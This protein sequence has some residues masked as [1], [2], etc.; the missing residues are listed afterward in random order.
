MAGQ[1]KL[2]DALAGIEMILPEIPQQHR[3]KVGKELE[4]LLTYMVDSGGH[5]DL[6][7]V[8]KVF[9]T[10][11]AAVKSGDHSIFLQRRGRRWQPV[12]IDQFIE[13]P[14][15]LGMRG[16]I[17]PKLFDELV[18]IFHGPDSEIIREIVLG[19]A[20]GCGKS[21]RAQIILA[22]QLYLLSCYHNP[23]VE[24]G[25]SSGS[26]IFFVFQSISLAL[27]KKVLFDQFSQLLRRGEYF[28][29]HFPYDKSVTSE[30]RFPND[31]TIMPIAS[32]DTSAL[33]LNV[34]SISLD[35]VNFQ[36]VIEHSNK[37]RF[38]GES[39]YNQAQ[40]LYDTITR[41]IKSRFNRQGKVPGKVCIMSS[42]F[43]PGDFVSRKKAEVDDYK[44]RGI[45][46]PIYFSS[47]SQWEAKPVGTFS[48]ETFL[49]EVGDD[50]RRSRIIT[51]LDEAVEL[52]DVVAVPM[53]FYG[54][55]RAD[56]DAAIRDIAGIPVG[57]SNF[58]IKDR[59]SLHE[60]TKTHNQ[61]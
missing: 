52:D 25:L 54:D 34:F 58:F 11:S 14:F 7:E 15:F 36:P 23:Q 57:G 6:E 46:C 37:A 29:K 44:A 18:D 5:L 39:E 2:R 3:S 33:G 43:Y 61:L 9:Q 21:L 56:I 13:D 48:D 51:K 59:E 28:Q 10:V 20:I 12:R 40:K 32:N 55:F 27:A 22:Y 47:F 4:S 30:L 45:P 60:A 19:G 42:A 17:W 24:Y 31:V 38:T 35:E 53:D 49:V 50:T 16:Q 41:R 26:S 1:I 8:T